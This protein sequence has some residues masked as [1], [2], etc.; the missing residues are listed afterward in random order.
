[1]SQK[2]VARLRRASKTR[3]RIRRQ[4]ILRLCVFKSPRHFYAQIIDQ[5]VG[6]VVVSASTIEPDFKKQHASGGNIDAAV[7][8][9]ARLADKARQAGV[10]EVAFDRSGYKYHGRIK[11]MADAAREGGLKF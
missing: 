9:G 5:N 4:G 7:K 10:I 2:K 3:N 6:Q 11:A 1:M 8:L